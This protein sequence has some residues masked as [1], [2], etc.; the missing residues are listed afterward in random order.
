M[1]SFSILDAIQHSA[2]GEC[3]SI[4]FHQSCLSTLSFASVSLFKVYSS[5]W[6]FPVMSQKSVQ[7]ILASPQFWWIPC[8]SLKHESTQPFVLGIFS[9]FSV[10]CWIQ[11]LLLTQLRR[12]V[13]SLLGLWWSNPEC[14]CAIPSRSFSYQRSAADWTGLACQAACC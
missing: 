12:L 10:F 8:W 14:I 5:Y 1:L 13:T 3:H 11:Q 2:Q 9:L 4:Q 7:P 6:I